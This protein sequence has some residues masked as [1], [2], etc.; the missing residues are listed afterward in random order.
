MMLLLPGFIL[1]LIV[2]EGKAL[3]RSCSK[4]LIYRK[5]TKN[6]PRGTSNRKLETG[7]M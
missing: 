2:T 5:S 4:K 1:N 3:N 7:K 6:Q